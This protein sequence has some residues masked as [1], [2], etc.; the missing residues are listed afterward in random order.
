MVPHLKI[1]TSAHLVGLLLGIPLQD[2]KWSCQSVV[3]L[4]PIMCKVILST[5][6][7]TKQK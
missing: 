4:L 5:E 6:N 3:E 7:K 1:Q 2:R